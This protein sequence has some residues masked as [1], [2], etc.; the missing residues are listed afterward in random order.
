MKINKKLL[1]KVLGITFLVLG[2]V[3]ITLAL[4]DFFQVVSYNKDLITGQ[5]PKETNVWYSVGAT[6]LMFG[7][8]FFFIL[9]FGTKK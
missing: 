1:F 2:A 6:P 4:V 9:G 5:T 3:M 8:L 7:G